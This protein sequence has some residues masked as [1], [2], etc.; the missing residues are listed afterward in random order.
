MSTHTA[1]R[2]GPQLAD[3]IARLRTPGFVLAGTA[4][5][6]AYIGSVS[7]YASGNYPVCPLY[8]VTGLYC[9]G[10]GSLRS[11]H[12]LANGDLLSAIARNP[13]MPPLML[14]LLLVF[15]RWV[16]LRS[17]GERLTWDPPAWVPIAIGVGVIVYGV[18]R[19][20]PGLEWLA[21]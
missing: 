20:I 17:R 9:P 21:P 19:N 1:Q 11:L 6:F 10:C 13:L 4:A 12:S 15:V 16:V 5:A 14:I 18:A 8:A 2:S 3:R 7:P